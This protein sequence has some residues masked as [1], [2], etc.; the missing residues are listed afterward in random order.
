MSLFLLHVLLA[1][2]RR[3]GGSIPAFPPRIVHQPAIHHGPISPASDRRLL[4]DLAHGRPPGPG[5]LSGRWGDFPPPARSNGAPIRA[6][7]GVD[8]PSRRRPGRTGDPRSWAD[9]PTLF[10]DLG[11]RPAEQRLGHRRPPPGPPRPS[12]STSPSSRPA[13]R[14]SR[15]PSRTGRLSLDHYVNKAV[16]HRPRPV[17]LGGVQ[18]VHVRP[19]APAG[20]DARLSSGPLAASGRYRLYTLNNESRELHEHRVKAFGLDQVLPGVPGLLLPRP[21][22][23][24]RGHL[25]QRPG[26]RR[27]RPRPGRLHRRPLP[28]RRAGHRPGPGRP[29]LPGPRRPPRVPQG[30]GRDGMNGPHPRGAAETMAY[31]DFTIADLRRGFGLAIEEA[32]DLF[33][34]VAE[35]ALPASLV[36]HPGAPPAP[37]VEPEHGEGPLGAGDCPGAGRVQ[38]AAPRPDQPVLRG[39]VLGRRGVWF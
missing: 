7:R 2:P 35:A 14:C 22:Q 9:A 38:A 29:P 23:A 34:H 39:R 27:H 16:F 36:G 19:V 32:D 10:F 1:A 11:G 26:D 17:H 5:G 12:G 21:G 30:P 25:P 4:V 31:S 20:G 33:A 28:E 3:L 37:G 13:T 18:G 15:P 6:R 8:G 24:R